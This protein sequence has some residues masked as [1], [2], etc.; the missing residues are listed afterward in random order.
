MLD[1]M[2]DLS[3]TVANPVH[4]VGRDLLPDRLPVMG[5]STRIATGLETSFTAA[6]LFV[7]VDLAI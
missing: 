7:A 4:V 3:K 2:S 6:N 5:P 1:H